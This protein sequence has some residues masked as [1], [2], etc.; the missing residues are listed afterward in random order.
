LSDTLV[1]RREP[2]VDKGILFEDL[3]YRPHVGQWRVHNSRARHRVLGCGV[4]WGKTKCAAHEVVSAALEPTFNPD[5]S[6]AERSCGWL[7]GPT[8]DLADKAYREVRA[9]FAGRL[10]YRVKKVHEQQKALWIY[11]I[12]GK[13]CE[14]RAKTAD[15][16]DSL[17][18]EGLDFV[19]IDEAARMRPS[20]W[21]SH[22]SQRLVD[23][24]GW[25]LKISSPKGKGWFYEEYRR[26]L[27]GANKDADYESWSAPTWQNPYI[28]RALIE[29]QR[30]RIPER[31]FR[32]EFEAEFIE[33]EGEVFR[34]VRECATVD[35]WSDPVADETY[36]AGLDLAI[37]DDFSVHT[38]VN[39][40]GRVV[41]ADRFRKLPW[42]RQVE[43]VRQASEKY[44]K[45]I[46]YVDTTGIGRPV[47]DALRHA[48]VAAREYT[49]SAPTKNSLVNNLAML[50]EQQKVAIPS[51]KLMAEFAEE[52]ESYE[53]SVT[54]KGHVS[55]SAPTG[56][57]DDVVISL[58]LAVWPLRPRRS[59]IVAMVG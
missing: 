27:P 37:V 48:G 8:Y 40:K 14:I 7:V 45:P 1:E 32:Q 20:T 59:P 26:G 42:E 12:A 52:L 25:S 22:L 9:I 4:R 58:G 33:G 54:D 10:H 55:T 49:L 36:Y 46:T 56:Y 29:A 53:Y 28:R 51:A 35:A 17:I 19:V 11:N 21:Q 57:H 50:L 43:R 38:I 13:L 44:R 24:D 2:I 5:G 6:L 16:E 18:G 47:Y 15:N 31:V 30:T 34:G 3:G 39:S 41:F 23:R